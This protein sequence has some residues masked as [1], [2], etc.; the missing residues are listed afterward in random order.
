MGYGIEIVEILENRRYS[1]LVRECL[2]LFKSPTIIQPS[3]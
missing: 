2:A 3:F 1:R